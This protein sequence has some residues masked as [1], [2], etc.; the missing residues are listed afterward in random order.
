M[1]Q[2]GK[3]FVPGEGGAP[4]GSI[5]SKPASTRMSR[6]RPGGVA[7]QVRT[8]QNAW[9]GQLDP[10][11]GIITK[12]GDRADRTGVT[13]DDTLTP[14]ACV[15][16]SPN[17]FS[18]G[19]FGNLHPRD[20]T[21]RPGVGT[22]R[23]E[24][25]APSPCPGRWQHG[26][27]RSSGN[28]TEMCPRYLIGHDHDHDRSS[29]TCE[30]FQPASRKADM[31][32]MKFR[33]PSNDLSQR[34]PDY[35][36]A[37]ITGLDRTPGR[38]GVEL[39]NGVMTC[40]RETT[41]SGRSFVPWP[42][43]GYGTPIVGTA[44]L[45]ERPAPYSLAV[46]LARGKLNDVRNQLADWVH[47]PALDPRARP[48]RWT[49][50]STSSSAPRRRPTSP[51]RA[52]PPPRPRSSRHPWR[53]TCSSKPTQPRS[54]R[55]GWRR[56]PSSRRT[57]AACSTT[58]R[59]RCRRRSNGRAHSTPASW[60]SPGGRWPRRRGST[61][62]TSSM[63]SLP[64]AVKPAGDRGR[65]VNRVSPGRRSRLAL[66]LGRGFRDH[67]RLGLPT[68][69]G[70]PFAI[71]RASA[72]LARGAPAASGE[73]LGL[74]EEEQIRIAARAVQ[75]AHQTD[76]S[77][78]LTIGI[79]RPWAEWMGSSHFQLGPLHLCDYLLRADWEFPAWRSR[80]RRDIPRR[81]ATSATC[82]NC[83]GCWISTRC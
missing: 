75:V 2:V 77:A 3:E 26:A 30:R 18:A 29:M 41:E 78:Q 46:E 48:R 82:S 79:D 73:I 70:R 63:P 55:A 44:T 62:G 20:P 4:S 9:H 56:L 33:L 5:G 34:L 6:K 31:G 74:T 12:S 57:W 50:P 65:A 32:V 58:S 8:D 36:K 52:C 21:V 39:R 64:G 22:D 43:D 19:R 10:F 25:V 49:R 47:G 60:A 14:P 38:V 68:S 61:A 53:A 37:Y 27:E 81:G 16:Q 54:F 28:G 59:K 72:A 35:R 80:S 69:S 83:P 13:E 51:M 40:L 15:G 76:P 71:P 7:E 11:K 45:A 66:A 24:P 1:R 23:Y 42:I 17:L 67:R